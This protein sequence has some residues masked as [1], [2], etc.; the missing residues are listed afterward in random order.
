MRKLW[1]VYMEFLLVYIS[2]YLQGKKDVVRLAQRWCLHSRSWPYALSDART[3]IYPLFI[4][5][6][7]VSH[8]RTTASPISITAR[9]IC[10]AIEI[11]GWTYLSRMEKM[12]TQGLTEATPLFRKRRRPAL[13]CLECR[14][15][16]IKCDRNDP[17]NHCK[18]SPGTTCLY[19]DVSP[20]IEN[21]SSSYLDPTTIFAASRHPKTQER[22]TLNGASTISPNQ[23]RDGFSSSHA[24]PQTTP[25]AVNHVPSEKKWNSAKG[26]TVDDASVKQKA[27]NRLDHNQLVVKASP[28]AVAVTYDHG[29]A[30]ETP[31]M[32]CRTFNTII[33]HDGNNG[34]KLRTKFSNR[35]GSAPVKES[36]YRMQFYGQSHWKHSFHGVNGSQFRCSIRN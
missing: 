28:N 32:H 23:K 5:Q 8:K 34:G 6:S 7:G 21:L 12:F 15:R 2:I 25:I 16:K 29:S 36:M 14:R 10:S 4:G 19:N 30:E 27:L 1:I 33:I 24:I 11:S 20:A 31:Q 18:R 9:Y 3:E 35:S 17:C 26:S 22:G 13:S